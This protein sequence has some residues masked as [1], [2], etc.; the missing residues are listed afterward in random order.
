MPNTYS[1]YTNLDDTYKINIQ[2]SEKTALTSQSC[3]DKVSLTQSHS[4]PIIIGSEPLRLVQHKRKC[5][6]RTKSTLYSIATHTCMWLG[7]LP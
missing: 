4:Q 5:Q 1:T 6:H 2:Y 7:Q 3:M